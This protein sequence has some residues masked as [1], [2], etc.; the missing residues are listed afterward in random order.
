M[1]LKRYFFDGRTAHAHFPGIGRYAVNLARAMAAH[2][3]EDEQ[4]IL[5][6]D[7]GRETLFH[8]FEAAHARVALLD[9]ALSPF[10]LRQQWAIPRVLREGRACVYHSPYLLMPFFPGTP[11]VVTIHDL[12]PLLFPTESS[13]KARL[14]FRFALWVALRVAQRVIV[15]SEAT[16]R[17][18]LS[19]HAGAADKTRVCLEAPALGFAPA[20]AQEIAAV[21]AKF[22]LPE[23]YA[24]Y[25]GSNK[26]HKNLLR[27]V[28][29]WGEM[30]PAPCALVIAGVLIPEYP[31]PECADSGPQGL[32]LLGRV[33][34]T[35]LRALYSGAE[36]FI[37]PSLYEGF[38]LPV[39]EAMA[40]GAAIACS[41][42]S[43]L[44]EVAGQAAVYFD[45]TDTHSM[46]RVLQDTLA[47][48]AAI[49]ALRHKSLA[50]ARLF[51]WEKAATQTLTLYRELA[52]GHRRK[53]DRRTVA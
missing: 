48:P 43:S 30:A 21:R 32:R 4:L 12:I 52:Q 9:V 17:D 35:D 50:R 22:G 16:R 36:L 42:S 13:A 27:L 2:I 26:P 20:S 47:A 28:Q 38:G 7:P 44:P 25:V 23:R 3:K 45:P 34:D 29:V 14:F 24:L 15:V 18:L 31:I 11:C 37:F 1:P 49:A 5:L 19:V 10:S 40:C 51:S 6:R 53:R 39:L 41:Q 8:G 46:R 33:D